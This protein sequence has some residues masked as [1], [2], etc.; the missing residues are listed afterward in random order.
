MAKVYTKHN[1]AIATFAAK[2]SGRFVING[3]SIE[4]GATVATDGRRII[5]VT[6]R[7]EET[8]N[9]LM[10]KGGSRVE[11]PFTLPS[12]QAKRIARG[13]PKKTLHDCFVP[14]TDDPNCKEKK[15]ARREDTK[16]NASF[17]TVLARKKG[18]P[19]LVLVEDGSRIVLNPR[20]IEG[21]FPKYQEVLE[22][23]AG[24]TAARSYFNPRLLAELLKFYEG[25]TRT[26]EFPHVVVELNHCGQVR[27]F[28]KGE[29]GQ[30]AEAVLMPVA[31]GDS[32]DERDEKKRMEKVA[33]AF[34]ESRGFK[35]TK[36]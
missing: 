22:F 4:P 5:R 18:A 33:K 25:F 31:V 9:G 34:L 17:A 7:E 13:L 35:V 10:P 30:K 21:A 8:V 26:V 6:A 32:E 1:F 3:I 16:R 19:A 12:A 27:L 20:P 2:E 11:K 24:N 36:K 15:R 28:A 29:D 14:V 23:A